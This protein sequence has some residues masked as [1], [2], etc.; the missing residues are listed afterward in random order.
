MPTQDQL[1]DFIRRRISVGRVQPSADCFHAAWY[2]MPYHFAPLPAFEQVAAELVQKDVKMIFDP[3]T[4]ELIKIIMP[5]ASKTEVMTLTV[6]NGWVTEASVE[7]TKLLPGVHRAMFRLQGG[8]W[9]T[10]E[11]VKDVQSGR[12]K[13][14]GV[15]LVDKSFAPV[16]FGTPA[17]VGTTPNGDYNLTYYARYYVTATPIVAGSV[18]ATATFTVSYP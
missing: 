11:I 16:T 9:V 8:E 14:V 1:A 13:F 5:F 3:V 4:K 15:Q 7:D 10:R 17:L 2:P 12:A 6:D 18:S